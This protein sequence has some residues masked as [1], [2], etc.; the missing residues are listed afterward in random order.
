MICQCP[1][2]LYPISA[3]EPSAARSFK[4]HQQDPVLTARQ[5]LH[6]VQSG[7]GHPVHIKL[8]L[9]VARVGF[10]HHQMKRSRT[11]VE[12]NELE[13]MIVVGQHEAMVANNR[14]I[15]FSVWQTLFQSSAVSRSP[16]STDGHTRKPAPRVRASSRTEAKSNRSLS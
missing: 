3:V 11:V 5:V 15:L 1:G 4:V 13:V 16:A 9:D 7:L 10:R 2:R 8:E 12:R 14:P 6:G